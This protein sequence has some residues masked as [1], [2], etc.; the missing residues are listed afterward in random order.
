MNRVFVLVAL[1]LTASNA[2]AETVVATGGRDFGG[3][4][5]PGVP[6]D[7]SIYLDNVIGSGM[8][9]TGLANPALSYVYDD[10]NGWDI[11]DYN[12]E[13]GLLGEVRIESGILVD[14]APGNLLVGDISNSFNWYPLPMLAVPEGVTLSAIG[15]EITHIEPMPIHDWASGAIIQINWGVNLTIKAY[16]TPEPSSF[17]LITLCMFALPRSFRRSAGYQS[18]K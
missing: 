5:G 10:V 15:F 12:F 6:H 11:V 7:L 13:P 18:R 1:L 2:H 3:Y 8:A 4:F 14:S 17:V 16:A 9:I